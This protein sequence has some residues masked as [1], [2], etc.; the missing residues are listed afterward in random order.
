MKLSL[1]SSGNAARVHTRRQY[2]T[3]KKW[4]RF[5]SIS[6]CVY[7]TCARHN[8]TY[9]SPDN[10][11][12]STRLDETNFFPQHGFRKLAATAA[13]ETKCLAKP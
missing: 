13:S 6:V 11:L 4:Q 1:S 7:R 5:F 3:L 8:C 12:S 10:V 9:L 2:F